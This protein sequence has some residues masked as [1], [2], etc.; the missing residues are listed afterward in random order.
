MP[1]QLMITG[2]MVNS[3][4]NNRRCF[5][6][7]TEDSDDVNCA[8]ADR[9]TDPFLLMINKAV[10]VLMCECNKRSDQEQNICI[11]IG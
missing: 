6:S 5:A 10:Y 8:R 3:W 11:L 4:R 7:I 2:H 9:H 1:K